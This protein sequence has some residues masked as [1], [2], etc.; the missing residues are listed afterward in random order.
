MWSEAQE[1]LLQGSAGGGP[2]EAPDDGNADVEGDG[3]DAPAG[4]PPAPRDVLAAQAMR[5]L[6]GAR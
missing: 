6:L 1:L 4:R 5:N 2:A 3:G